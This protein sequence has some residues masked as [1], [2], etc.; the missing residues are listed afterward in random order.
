MKIILLAFICFWA[1][2][3]IAPPAPVTDTRTLAWT[4]DFAANPEVTAFKLYWSVGPANIANWNGTN[5]VYGIYT[6][7]VAI[8]GQ[9]TNVVFPGML[10]GL[11]YYFVV[12]AVN[13][14][15]AVESDYSNE[16]KHLAPKKGGAPKDLFVQ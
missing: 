9:V 5:I 2:P 4:Y 10:R 7:L 6:N 16:C 8:P 14:N 12:T 11:T 3:C 1:L 15:N 13:T